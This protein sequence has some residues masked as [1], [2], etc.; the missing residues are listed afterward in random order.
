ME[1]KFVQAGPARLQYFDHGNG[2]ET[3]VLVHGY[4]SSGRVWGLTQQALDQAR[5]R[6]IALCNRG[7]GD[8][9]RSGREED[10]TIDAFANDLEAAVQALALHDFTLVGHSMGGATVTRYALDHPERLKALVLV[11]PAPLAGRPLRDGW[12]E[13]IRRDFEAG[14]LGEETPSPDAT[15]EVLALRQALAADIVRNPLERMIAGR[16]SMASLRLREQLGDLRVPVLVIGGD[17]D[18]TVGVD[19]ILAEYL[20]LPRETRSLQIVHGAGHSPN[21]E[22]AADFAAVLDRFVTDTLPAILAPA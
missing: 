3:L 1:A 20:A 10:Y 17:R 6:T 15:R 4:R 12:D 8:S 16:R 2:L 18:T 13:Q 22:R 7:A 9:D 11:D 5:F 21:V 14:S 19:N